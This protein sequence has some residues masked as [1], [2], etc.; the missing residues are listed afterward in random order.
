M[1]AIN[2]ETG[3]VHTT[4]T[5]VADFLA[6]KSGPL[7]S[8][9]SLH[10]FHVDVE[11]FDGEIACICLRYLE[12]GCLSAGSVSPADGDKYLQRVA[13]FPLFPYAALFWPEHLRT[14]TRP[15]LDLSSLFFGK[16]S[17]VRKNWW[18]CYY[19]ITTTKAAIL[20]PRGDFTLLHMAAYLNLPFLAQQLEY[21]GEVHSRINTRDSFG[22]TPL[23]WA[24]ATGSMEMFVFLLQ[25]RASQE[26]VGETIFEVACRKGQED[27]VKYL[28]DSGQDVNARV[29]EQ[30]ILQ[31][32]GQATRW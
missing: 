9:A 4:H 19:A 5:S 20:A 25:R 7:V 10:R 29:A 26:C 27:I 1:L 6:D 22:S 13:Q 12:Q 15:Y 30:S 18:M 3:E 28:L 17:V 24:A 32:L 23:F 8:D 11:A 31:T 14:A 2:E 16:K 21:M